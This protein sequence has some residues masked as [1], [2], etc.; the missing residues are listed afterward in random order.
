MG[1]ITDLIFSRSISDIEALIKSGEFNVSEYVLHD[2]TALSLAASCNYIDVMECLIKNGADV[3]QQ[4]GGDLGYTPIEEAAR[5][6]NVD[7]IA[8]LL[9]HGAEIDKGNTINSNA[10]IGACIGAHADAVNMLLEKGSNINHADDNGQTALHYLCRYAKQWGS[11]TITQTVDGVT[12]ELENPRFLQHTAIF[13]ILIDKG[14][15]VTLETN[16]GYTPLHLCAE[17][18]ADTFI[19]PIVAKGGNVNFQNSKGF[20]PLHAA[21]ERSNVAACAELLN[22]GADVNIVDG[23]G[24][25]AILAAVS[26]LNAEMV[27]LF[28]EK[29]A[30]KDVSSKI[31]YGNVNIGDTPVTLAEKLNNAEVISALN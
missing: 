11:F 8:L 20:T 29:G 21:A 31:N 2:R 19:A 1:K 28:V 6:G 5:E 3:N 13:N 27:R 15:D 16:Y 4:N 22:F 17:S 14:A 9:Q 26:A 10:L 18:G 30:V 7:A 12:T 25:T 23:D 24:F